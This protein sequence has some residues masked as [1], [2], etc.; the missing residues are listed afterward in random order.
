MS[1]CFRVFPSKIYQQCRV[2]IHSLTD[3]EQWSRT[4]KHDEAQL[5]STRLTLVQDTYLRSV[6]Q[7]RVYHLNVGRVLNWLSW[8]IWVKLP[9]HLQRDTNTVE[10]WEDVFCFFL[11]LLSATKQM[12]V[13]AKSVD[14]VKWLPFIKI[15]VKWIKNIWYMCKDLHVKQVYLL[16]ISGLHFVFTLPFSIDWVCLEPQLRWYQKT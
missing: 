10:Q 12:N 14:V 4:S 6:F 7:C 16:L 2:W 15:C 8:Q 9:W 1:W 13:W 5:K 3:F 11:I